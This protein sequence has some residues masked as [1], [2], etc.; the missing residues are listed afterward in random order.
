MEKIHF[1][2]V[3]FVVH[4]VLNFFCLLMKCFLFIKKKKKK[5]DHDFVNEPNYPILL[6]QYS[7][8]CKSF[9]TNGMFRVNYGSIYPLIRTHYLVLSYGMLIFLK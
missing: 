6:R 4:D 2:I 3:L 7:N 5:W 1:S 9:S 8:G